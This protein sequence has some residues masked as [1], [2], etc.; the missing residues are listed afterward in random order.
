MIFQVEGIARTSKGPEA[1]KRLTRGR[2]SEGA[3]LAGARG[4]VAGREQGRAVWG[5]EW[6][7]VL[8]AIG[9]CGRCQSK[10]V[11]SLMSEALGMNPTV[12]L[13]DKGSL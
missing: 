12:K 5:L 6:R 8:Q 4:P 9:R 13:S 11:D 1:G 10:D 2:V 3:R 7:F